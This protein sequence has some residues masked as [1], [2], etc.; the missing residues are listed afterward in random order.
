M[1]TCERALAAALACG[2]ALVA[3]A[4]TARAQA[5]DQATARALFDDGRKLM[6]AGDYAGACPKFDAAARTYPSAGILLN[7]G[8]CY[9]K[10]GKT[11]SAWTE[12]GD[13][14]SLATRTHRP[15]DAAEAR[16]RQAAIEP[17]LTRLVVHVGH[18]V[19]GLTVTRDGE[20][21]APGAWGVPIPVDPG[22]HDLHAEA[23]G[24]LPWSST[25]DVEGKGQT[26][27]VEIPAPQPVPVAAP[28]PPPVAMT[29]PAPASQSASGSKGPGAAPW[30]L[31]V[32]GGV[33]GAAGAVTMI[34]ASGASS[35]AS[36]H[37]DLSGYNSDKTMWTVGLVGA[38]V[39]GAAA[40]GGV[41]WLVTSHGHAP[42]QTTGLLAAPW[43]GSGSAGVNVAGSF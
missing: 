16:K 1:T 7:L 30:A 35:T 29:E 32:A 28:A 4:S 38:I 13:A 18:E 31:L 11:A 41:V 19:P 26:V 33:V 3:Q 24:Y 6:K 8:D 14:A 5:E 25:T 15:D 43:A 42:S 40:A 36:S 23:A 37:D 9:E 34:V 22:N 39:G 10:V 12:F 17:S 27:T 20:A 21:I 2:L